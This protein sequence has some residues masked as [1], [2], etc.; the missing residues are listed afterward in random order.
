MKVSSEMLKISDS[1]TRFHLRRSWLKVVL[2]LKMNR[3]AVCMPGERRRE[4]DEDKTEEK[5]KE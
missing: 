4:K 3:H 2:E 5:K 1:V